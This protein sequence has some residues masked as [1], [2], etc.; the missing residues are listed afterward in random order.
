MSVM[1]GRWEL[2]GMSCDSCVRHVRRALDKLGVETKSVTIGSAEI[3]YD[4]SKVKPE[5]IT[6][7]LG[8]AGYPARLA[9][10]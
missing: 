3:A 5:Q 1:E 6:D 10:P 2:S 8:K 7:A 4:P 9:V